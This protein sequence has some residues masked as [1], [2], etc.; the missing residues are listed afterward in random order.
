MEGVRILKA[1]YST[2]RLKTHPRP[3]HI[4]NR[5]Y[6]VRAKDGFAI[7]DRMSDR[8]SNPGMWMEE[9]QATFGRKIP[10]GNVEQIVKELNHTWHEEIR[11][12]KCQHSI[13]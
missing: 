6:F 8:Y 11:R 3:P 1:K 5:Y 4:W 2:P 7:I 13:E 12:K 9:I 10:V